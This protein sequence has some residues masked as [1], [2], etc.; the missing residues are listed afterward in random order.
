MSL[1]KGWISPE[2]GTCNEPYTGRRKQEGTRRGQG[3][4]TASVGAPVPLDK[5]CAS[6]MTPN[7]RCADRLS[8]PLNHLMAVLR[9][10]A[11][12]V[13]P[14]V[15]STRSPLFTTIHTLFAHHSHTIHTYSRTIRALFAHYSRTIRALFAHYSR[16]FTSVH[17]GSRRFAPIHVC[18]S[19]VRTSIRLCSHY[20]RYFRRYSHYSRGIRRRQLGSAVSS[21]CVNG[22]ELWGDTRF[23][24]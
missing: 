22:P 11:F 15:P 6:L 20:L 12:A 1:P 9:H 2:G 10:V 17:I 8:V 16:R 21:Q 3:V 18:S 24:V 4:W 19:L 23:P 7:G 13:R 5:W 14:L